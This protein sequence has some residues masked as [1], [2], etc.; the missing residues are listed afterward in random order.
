[1]FQPTQDIIVIRPEKDIDKIGSILL[2]TSA[3]KKSYR[4]EI[5]AVGPDTTVSVGQTA[6]Y[7]EHTQYPIWYDGEE[8]LIVHEKHLLGVMGEG[9]CCGKC[10][11]NKG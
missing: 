11:H 7:T 1:M 8:F 5:V 3:V 2:A 4:G 6:V 10:K 9:N